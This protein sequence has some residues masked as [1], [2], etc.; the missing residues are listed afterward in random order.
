[1]EAFCCCTKY[2]YPKNFCLSCGRV[3]LPIGRMLRFYPLEL[4]ITLI[5]GSSEEKKM[6][7][8]ADGL[9]YV[10]TRKLN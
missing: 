7:I 5:T 4:Y 3:F 8:K 10:F 2:S 6:E 1:M 9:K